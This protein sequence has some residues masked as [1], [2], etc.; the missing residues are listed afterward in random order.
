MK[1]WYETLPQRAKDLVD[2]T[3][4]GGFVQLLGK[5]SN[6]CFQLTALAE[7]WWDTTNTLHLP[8]GEATMTPLDFAAITGIRV[9]GSPIPFD[10]EL[11]KNRDALVYF[12]GQVPEMTEAGTVRHSWFYQTFKKHTCNTQRDYEHVARA[13][14]LH[15]FGVALFPNKDSRV[16][17]HYLAAMKDLSTVRE[18]DWGGAALSTLYG[19]MGA[20]SRGMT[21]GM[22]GYLRVWEV[23]HYLTALHSY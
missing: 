2:G 15:L 9:G 20:I 17:L 8:F 5:T 18:Y 7:R 6:N 11:Y 10:V 14:I 4:F 3:G 12:L 16:H 23:N 21:Q 1:E 13:F 19:H 22:G